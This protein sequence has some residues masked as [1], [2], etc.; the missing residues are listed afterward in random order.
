MHTTENTAEMRPLTDAE[1]DAASGGFL[2]IIG[3]LLGAVATA[4]IVGAVAADVKT[5]T[6]IWNWPCGND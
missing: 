5:C 6:S 1:L 4:L 3:K 2:P